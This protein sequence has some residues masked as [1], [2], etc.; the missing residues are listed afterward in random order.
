MAFKAIYMDFDDKRTELRTSF[1]YK[2]GEVDVDG[3]EVQAR[4]I[5]LTNATGLAVFRSPAG[6]SIVTALNIEGDII[7]FFA[8][9]DKQGV[10][11]YELQVKTEAGVAITA[12]NRYEVLPALRVVVTEGMQD[13]AHQ[14]AQ[15]LS[16]LNIK[17]EQWQLEQDKH[18]QAELER[19]NAFEALVQHYSDLVR[20]NIQRFSNYDARFVV[21]DARLQTMREDVDAWLALAESIIN[22]KVTEVNNAINTM[23][24]NFTNKEN[25]LTSKVDASISKNETKTQDCI[26][27]ITEALAAGTTDL[28]TK[29][30]R[31]DSF[32]VTHDV[33]KTRLDTHEQEIYGQLGEMEKV[34]FIE[35]T[36]VQ[37]T[38]AGVM[39]NTTLTGQTLVNLLTN[40]A[41]SN[42]GSVTKVSDGK[43]AFES[44]TGTGAIYIRN[45]TSLKPNTTYTFLIEMT[46]SGT[47]NNRVYLDRTGSA[48]QAVTYIE[49]SSGSKKIK[50]T[51]KAEILESELLIVV[52]RK[53]DSGGTNE[54]SNLVLLEGDHTDKPLEF[55]EGLKSSEL[56][57][58]TTHGENLFDVY[59]YGEIPATLPYNNE[60]AKINSDRSFEFTANNASTAGNG[61]RLIGLTPGKKYKIGGICTNTTLKTHVNVDGDKNWHDQRMTFDIG[62]KT[63]KSRE[64]TV[65]NKGELNISFCVDGSGKS[66]IES[67][68]MYELS[69]SIPTT[70]IPYQSSTTSFPA[71]IILR[72]L[73]NGVADTYDFD[74]QTLTR[75]CGE[76]VLNGSASIK[77]ITTHADFHLFEV[78]VNE[79]APVITNQKLAFSD[80]FN[81]LSQSQFSILVEGVYANASVLGL[82]ILKSKLTTP[83]VAGFKAWLAQ[84]PTTVVYQLATPT[85]TLNDA[86]VLLPED[87]YDDYVT[88]QTPGGILIPGSENDAVIMPGDMLVEVEPR[89]SKVKVDSLPLSHDY[90]T[91]IDVPSVVPVNVSTRLSKGRP[92][93]HAEQIA[94]VAKKIADFASSIDFTEVN[95]AISNVAQR[96]TTLTDTVNTNTQVISTNTNNINTTSSN[97]A[98]LTNEV[99]T[100]V[101]TSIPSKLDKTLITYGTSNPLDSDGKPD[102]TLYFKYV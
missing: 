72:S 23:N 40:G 39:K 101:Q 73:P 90:T 27:D 77:H 68:Y 79:N 7:Q 30:A 29:N 5:D 48:L 19:K 66:L 12:T 35:S 37:G 49:N 36:T 55:F 53:S 67:F 43:Y 4:N 75:R 99:K 89:T 14:L 83:D 57:T 74:T 25:E 45:L 91:T 31:K 46:V 82:K 8:P 10:Y 2:S 47:P 38:Q 52:A 58:V 18:M 1:Y 28:E 3:I 11:E 15:M 51:T 13:L 41:W 76:V 97:L 21:Y 69:S 65:P 59:R 42:T 64:I 62:T 87:D 95:T 26:D 60:I 16:H 32:D 93:A 85:Q 86:V 6:E 33:L 70:Y 84:N 24:A 61:L 81:S 56:E 20:D 71:P 78:S 54:V 17:I 102:G 44:T 94:H 80:R 100:I 96:V 34:D 9:S 88:D 22:G 63:S 92:N 98:T 50:V